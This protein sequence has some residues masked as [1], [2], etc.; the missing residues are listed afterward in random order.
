MIPKEGSHM[1]DPRIRQTFL[2]IARNE[3]AIPDG[4]NPAD[5][6][7]TSI[8]LLGTTD[9]EFR[10]RYVY[11]TLYRWILSDA[12]DAQDLRSFHRA[13]LGEDV[14]FSG[15][16]KRESDSVFLRAFA[17]LLLVPTLARHRQRPYLSER[18]IDETSRAVS[19]YLLEERD[20][21]GF[22]SSEK[23]WAHGIAHAAD[24]VGQLFECPQT[25]RESLHRL[26][27]AAA[28]AMTPSAA[29]Y[30]HEEDARMAAAVLRLWK[31]EILS[32]EEIERWLE[33]VIPKA[34]FTGELPGVHVN[35]VNARNFM[36]CLYFQAREEALPA[37]LILLVDNA[38]EAFPAR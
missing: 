35:Y 38:H 31:R 4:V 28:H 16:G 37:E 12:L 2:D 25:N 10:E 6:I 24:A 1:V 18:D 33:T 20:L 23:W 30:A 13:L 9:G 26:L 36:R 19:R 34:R 17:V 27:S 15:I 11:G 22:V 29:V 8:P 7:R 32:L 3:Y 14:L 5:F 21:R